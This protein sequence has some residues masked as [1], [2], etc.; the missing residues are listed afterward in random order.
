VTAYKVFWDAGWSGLIFN[1]ISETTSL[2]YTKSADVV[3]GK[4]YNFRVVAVNAVGDSSA[5][6]SLPVIASDYPQAPL[7]LRMRAQSPTAI[8]FS[9]N[10]PDDG[11]VPIT[12][13]DV[14][15]NGDNI[16]VET[17]A[18]LASTPT[19]S[20]ESVGLTPG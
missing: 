3:T 9:W 7:L 14:Y 18:L 10:Q 8:S 16:G 19:T 15:W 11:G 5:S 20:Y 2:F 13:Y 12:Q 1:Q 17:F 6:V 4:T